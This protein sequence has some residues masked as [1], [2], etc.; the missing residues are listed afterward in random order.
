MHNKLNITKHSTVLL[1]LNY[2]VKNLLYKNVN[3]GN[4]D[5]NSKIEPI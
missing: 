1:K 3:L 2:F 5:F 4:T